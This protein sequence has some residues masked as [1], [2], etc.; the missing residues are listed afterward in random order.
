MHLVVPVL[1]SPS[2][3]R[4]CATPLGCGRF[5]EGAGASQCHPPGADSALGVH[6]NLEDC[7]QAFYQAPL[8]VF[9]AL[10]LATNPSPSRALPLT[11]PLPPCSTTCASKITHSH[12]QVGFLFSFPLIV[13]LSI[14]KG[15][16]QGLVHFLQTLP[17]ALVYH[18][19]QLQTK[20]AFFIEGLVRGKGGYIASQRGFGLD[21]LGFVDIYTTFAGSHIHPGI[22]LLGWVTLYAMYSDQAL[23]EVAL[24]C[25]FMVMV[26][27]CWIGGPVLFNPFPSFEALS[28]DVSEMVQWLRNPLPTT[29][30]IAFLLF[31][32]CQACRFRDWGLSSALAGFMG[33]V[34]AGLSG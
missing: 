5:L 26:V 21:R 8:G 20:G 19:F 16:M 34:V 2:A 4:C 17:F 14:E 32:V 10:T 27:F 30:D 18:L 7:C 31:E 22:N 3:L 12:T 23:K 28:L 9:C 15:I 25:L 11:L 24:R 6:P 33:A 1:Y 13:E 29:K